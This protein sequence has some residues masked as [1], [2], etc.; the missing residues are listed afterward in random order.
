MKLRK[1]F[2]FISIIMLLW[3]IISGAYLALPAEYKE[4]IP[5]FNWLTALI[6]GGSTGVLGASILVVDSFI[7][8]NKVDV[9]SKYIDLA[10]KFLEIRSDYDNIKAKYK[11]L[12]T[13]INENTNVQNATNN[14]LEETNRLLKIDLESK[15]SN[16]LVEEKIKELIRG[17]G[18]GKQE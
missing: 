8:K 10:T 6:S 16:P 2:N 11:E 7:K 1:I 17:E 3:T 12:E 9:D 18:I 13:K 14:A 4:L 5:E 15:L